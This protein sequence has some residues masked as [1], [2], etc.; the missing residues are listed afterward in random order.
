MFRDT[1]NP[2]TLPQAV[3]TMAITVA[4][5]ASDPTTISLN[6]QVT[7]GSLLPSYRSSDLLRRQE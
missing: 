5:S 3:A 7:T 6:P 4:A 1:G 2:A